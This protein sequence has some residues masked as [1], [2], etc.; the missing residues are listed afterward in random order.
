M[1]V[2]DSNIKDHLIEVLD[3][4]T[5]ITYLGREDVRKDEKMSKTYSEHPDAASQK[6]SDEARAA[7]A[8]NL[9]D[10]ISETTAGQN[11]KIDAGGVGRKAKETE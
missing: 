8:Q 9:R 10:S 2:L 1:P 7:E 3:Y 4:V 5:R 6:A 11:A